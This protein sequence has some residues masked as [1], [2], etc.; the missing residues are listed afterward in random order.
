VS[1]EGLTEL[2]ADLRAEREVLEGVLAAQPYAAWDKPSPAEGWLLR[3]VVAHLA[4]SDDVAAASAEG[5]PRAERGRGEGVLS[6]AQLGARDMTPAELLT[7]YRRAND[8]LLGALAHYDSNSRLPWA[9]RQMSTLSFTSARL[10]EHWSHGLDILEAAGVT[11]VDTERLRHVAHL[12]FITRD[13]AYRTHGREPPKT[14]LYV[15]LVSPAGA[16]WR[17]G[18]ADAPDR[19]R[20]RAGDFCRVVTQRIHV[21]DTSL[22]AEGAAA[23]EFLTLAQA[24][25]GPP[26]NGRPPKGQGS[27]IQR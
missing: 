26:G 23:R 21:D 18:P 14:P 2:L 16:I 22:R 17:W 11:P 25:A 4:E 3:D 1:D 10:M 6:A 9:G 24:F 15:E 7:W 13:F 19:I 27:E 12:G 5:L 8:R 20:G